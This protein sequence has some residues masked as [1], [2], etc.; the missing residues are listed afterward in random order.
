MNP[1]RRRRNKHRNRLRAVTHAFRSHP[2][3]PHPRHWARGPFF[4]P[5]E[6]WIIDVAMRPQVVEVSG[7]INKVHTSVSFEAER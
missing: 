1:A 7:R 6:G 3:F 2:R 4:V 5:G